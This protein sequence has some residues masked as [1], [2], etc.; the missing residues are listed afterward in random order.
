VRNYTKRRP[1]LQSPLDEVVEFNLDLAECKLIAAM[2]AGNLTTICFY[3]RTKGSTAAMSSC[4][5]TPARTA[6]R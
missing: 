5:K 1:V 6:S 2:A 4:S 3:L